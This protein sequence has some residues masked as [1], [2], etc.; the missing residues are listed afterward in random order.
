M[1]PCSVT[2]S[3]CVLKTGY[4]V[5]VKGLVLLFVPYITSLLS[6]NRLARMHRTR[7][8][9]FDNISLGVC[10]KLSQFS[11]LSFT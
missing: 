6:L 9:I 10:L 11:Q 5:M 4:I 3:L 2:C 8:M 7:Q 1:P